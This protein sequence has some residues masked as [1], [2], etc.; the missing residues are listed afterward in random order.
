MATIQLHRLQ[1]WRAISSSNLAELQCNE[2][3]N[4]H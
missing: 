1:I 2:G 3:A 4:L